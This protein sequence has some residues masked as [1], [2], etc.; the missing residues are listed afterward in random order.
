[1]PPLTADAGVACDA[2]PEDWDADATMV[3]VADAPAVTDAAEG[4]A[5]ADKQI[6]LYRNYIQFTRSLTSR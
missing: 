6:K 5:E 3:S 4:P 1:M 2:A